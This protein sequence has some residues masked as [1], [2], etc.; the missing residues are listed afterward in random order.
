VQAQALGFPNQDEG[1]F[2]SSRTQ[3]EHLT[4]PGRGEKR[5]EDWRERT[6]EAAPAERSA[7]CLD[8]RVAQAGGDPMFIVELE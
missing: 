4:L 8:D 7:Q 3:V 5:F 6:K 1:W 2:P